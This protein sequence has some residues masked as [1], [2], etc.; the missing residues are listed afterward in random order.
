MESRSQ[1]LR[2]ALIVAWT[3]AVIVFIYVPTICIALASVTILYNALKDLSVVL[4]LG[5]TGLV[6]LG[7]GILAVVMRERISNLAE[8]FSDWDS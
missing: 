3:L 6:L 8:R 4:I 1:R 2:H 5:I 7:L